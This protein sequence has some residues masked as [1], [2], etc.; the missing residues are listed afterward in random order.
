MKNI[1][2]ILFFC[3]LFHFS[4]KSIQ[5]I[6]IYDGFETPSIKKIW[7]TNKFIPGAVEIQS[8]IVR[9]GN[10]AAKITLHEGNQIHQE[11]GT[12]LE[13]AELSE[14]RK[15]WS[16]EDSSYSYSFSIFVPLD[17]PI[18]QNRLVLAQWKQ[19]C[20]IENCYPDNP[21]IAIRYIAG[22]LLITHKI[23]QEQN[24]LY[25][26]TEDIRN[27]WLDFKFQTRF[28]KLQNGQIIAWLNDEMIV[29][30][31]GINAY[32][33]KG[34]YPKINYFYFKIGLYRDKM[35]EPMTIYIDEYRKQQIPSQSN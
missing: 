8:S 33:E 12:I 27:R 34:G 22:E 5:G 4:C 32:P 21:V 19:R 15:L 13:R 18:V 26:T 3:T 9:A 20:P 2:L 11:K 30:Y 16:I 28:S 7:D 6:N 10:S 24:V 1:K 35:A 29:N 31:K 17:F 25:K 23:G 14:K